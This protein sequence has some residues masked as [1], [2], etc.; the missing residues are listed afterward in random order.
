[1]NDRIMTVF[2]WYKHSM[3]LAGKKID[4]PN[5]TDKRKTYLWRQLKA[6]IEK[7]DE[8]GFDD[9]DMKEIVYA[10]VKYAQEKKLLQRGSGLLARVD[11]L[12]IYE[13]KLAE[14]LKFESSFLYEIEQ[15][16][17]FLSEQFK[18]KS[19]NK[20]LLD[21]KRI[22]AYA[23]ITRWFQSGRITKNF[24]ALSKSC[25]KAL[26]R[27]DQDERNEF[28]PDIALLRMRVLCLQDRQRVSEISQIM[29]SDLHRRT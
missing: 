29:G 3:K 20:S 7:V 5:G 19:A 26:N 11:I 23:N 16:K 2:S 22:G 21:R 27:L 28:P 8:L 25:C 4:F 15:C 24:I 1:M 12:E 14:D 10:L 17:L 9:N 13:R 6:F 18:Q